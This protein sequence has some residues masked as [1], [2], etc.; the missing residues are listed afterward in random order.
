MINNQLLICS[1]LINFYFFVPVLLVF[2]YR[3]ILKSIARKVSIFGVFL[4]RIFPQSDWIR[5]DTPYLRMGKN[6]DQ[7]HSEYGHF[8]PSGQEYNT[9]N[10]VLFSSNQIA[11]IL[12]VTDSIYIDAYICLCIYIYMYKYNIT[13][14]Y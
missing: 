10:I 2:C 4:V 7:K 12:Y 8:L 1:W 13:C 3:A 5:R 14:T 11:D 9:D 6:T